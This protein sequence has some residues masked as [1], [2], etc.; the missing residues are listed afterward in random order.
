MRG[1]NRKGGEAVDGGDQSG[2]NLGRVKKKGAGKGTNVSKTKQR[3][4]R[5]PMR[6]DIRSDQTR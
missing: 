3:K 6:K 5:V 1:K 2:V 4:G